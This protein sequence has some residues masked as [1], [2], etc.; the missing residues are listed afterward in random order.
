MLANLFFGVNPGH[1]YNK[2]QKGLNIKSKNSSFN[3]ELKKYLNKTG[4]ESTRFI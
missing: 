1:L 3:K 2:K 4:A